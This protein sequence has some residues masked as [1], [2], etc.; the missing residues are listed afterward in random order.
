[1]ISN[2]IS[3]KCSKQESEY[4]FLHL[5]VRLYVRSKHLSTEKHGALDD[6]LV[7]RIIEMLKKQSAFLQR[8]LGENLVVTRCVVQKYIKV[9]KEAGRIVRVGGKCYGH[10]ETK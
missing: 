9:F 8:R 1:M 10:W 2:V 6:E 4:I 3:W 7:L 5:R